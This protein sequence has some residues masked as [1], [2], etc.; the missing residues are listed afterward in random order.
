[1]KVQTLDLL[2]KG[3][4]STI[5][6]MQY[7]QRADVNHTQRTKPENQCMNKTKILINKII[8]R[9][10]VKVFQMKSTIITMKNT[11]EEFNHIFEQAIE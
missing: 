2:D 7:T 1:M 4:N 6:N 9:E 8:K 3:I 10:Q 5:L 11:L